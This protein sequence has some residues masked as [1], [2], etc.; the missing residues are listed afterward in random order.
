MKPEVV[1][2]KLQKLEERV[3]RV[4][5]YAQSSPG[6]LSANRDALDIVTLNIMLAVQT[7]LDIASH[8]IADEGWTMASS[9]AESIERLHEHGVLSRPT[10]DALRNATGLRNVVVHA[11]DSIDVTLLHAGATRGVADLDAFAREVTT[12]LRSRMTSR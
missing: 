7:C 10:A 11:Y 5:A 4:R 9:L 3:A 8:I 2:A 12:W 6:E 1:V